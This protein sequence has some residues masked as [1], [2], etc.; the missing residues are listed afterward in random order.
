MGFF[1]KEEDYIKDI[2]I[3]IGDSTELIEERLEIT[4]DKP[5][6]VIYIR[7]KYED[8]VKHA[9]SLKVYSNRKSNSTSITDIFIN[10]CSDDKLNKLKSYDKKIYDFTIEL[11][12][13]HKLLL[14]E[15]WNLHREDPRYDE[16]VKIIIDSLN[17]NSQVQLGKVKIK[18][19]VLK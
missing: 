2:I 5:T 8:N 9:P 3:V 14:N 16:I 19:V 6:S 11:I 1:Y 12:E 7:S 15:L 4:V 10:N 17:N 18:K 13:Q